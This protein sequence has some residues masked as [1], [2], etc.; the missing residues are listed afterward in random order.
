MYFFIP[1]LLKD[2]FRYID[3]TRSSPITWWADARVFHTAATPNPPL[4]RHAET[5]LYRNHGNPGCNSMETGLVASHT[6][7]S[8]SQPYKV[9]PIVSIEFLV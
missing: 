3:Y 9:S 7:H 2:T 6:N 1:G 8:L 4:R 5:K